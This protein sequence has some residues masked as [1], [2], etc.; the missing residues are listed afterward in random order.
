MKNGKRHTGRTGQTDWADR[1]DGK[2]GRNEMNGG[3]RR[4]GV[5]GEMGRGLERERSGF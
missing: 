2:N 4:G 5:D 1:T 3:D